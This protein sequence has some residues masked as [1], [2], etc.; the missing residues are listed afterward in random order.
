[1][2]TGILTG[3]TILARNI[4]ASNFTG[5]GTIISNLDY[6]NIVYNKPDWTVYAIKSNV[7]S[8]LNSFNMNKQTN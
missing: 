2:L 7:D 6:N 1:M 8:S 5:S 3:T 4:P